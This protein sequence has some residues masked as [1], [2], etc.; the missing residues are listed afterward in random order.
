LAYYSE[1]LP[2]SHGEIFASTQKMFCLEYIKPLLC[3]LAWALMAHGDRD[4]YYL[5]DILQD[6]LW[7]N[8]EL[9]CFSSR[10]RREILIF[11]KISGDFLEHKRGFL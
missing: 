5:V 10:R 11:I 2:G 9:V 3:R 7:F 1:W 8:E 4:Y 6:I